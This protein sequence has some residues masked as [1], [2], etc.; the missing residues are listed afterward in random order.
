VVTH[1][2]GEP[3]QDGTSHKVWKM[4]WP[5]DP[6]VNMQEGKGGKAK[7][8]QVKQAVCAIDTLAEHQR[9]LAGP[10]APQATP[11]RGHKTEKRKR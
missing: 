6:R 9:Q 10:P 8:Y 1:Y 3:R 2:F 7:E 5:G 4:P 11:A